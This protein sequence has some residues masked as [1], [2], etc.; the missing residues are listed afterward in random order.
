[1]AGNDESPGLTRAD[2]VHRRP[3]LVN[4][5]PVQ[6]RLATGIASSA[7][8][9][10]AAWHRERWSDGLRQVKRLSWVHE[11]GWPQPTG[12]AVQS[13]R[14]DLGC[15]RRAKVAFQSRA[16]RRH[17]LVPAQV[18]ILVFHRVPES[19][20]DGRSPRC[21]AP[22]SVTRN[23][24]HGSGAGRSG[25]ELRPNQNAF[26]GPAWRR[27]ALAVCRLGMPSGTAK[28]RSVSRLCQ[29]SWLPF[30]SVTV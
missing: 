1:V 20:D 26:G 27:I 5:A 30:P 23:R 8:S 29:T 6:R 9:A 2:S 28:F 12:S 17:G 3:P 11:R 10:R 21:C 18:D 15:G 22:G 19:F 24:G 14:R 25:N 16:H 7:N 13:C 4:A